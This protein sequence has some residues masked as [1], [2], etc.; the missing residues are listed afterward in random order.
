[1]H[2]VWDL[3]LMVRQGEGSWVY[4]NRETS[5]WECLEGV[6]GWRLRPLA[7]FEFWDKIETEN[8]LKSSLIFRTG[9]IAFTSASLHMPS[10]IMLTMALG[11]PSKIPARLIPS[12][13]VVGLVSGFKIDFE[14]IN[15]YHLSKM[16][17]SG[18]HRFSLAISHIYL[19][20]YK[21][22]C[23]FIYLPQSKI[24]P[25]CWMVQASLLM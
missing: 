16:F 23:F 14:S 6:G 12:F 4:I 15:V 21:F 8:T 5:R 10:W 3:C 9:N 2:L 18:F 24:S 7:P 13:T 22:I 11:K 20:I 25:F 19:Q 1:M 17:E